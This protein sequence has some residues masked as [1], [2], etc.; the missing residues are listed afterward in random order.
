MEQQEPIHINSI[1]EL[2][3]SPCYPSKNLS[4]SVHTALDFAI[5]LSYSISNDSVNPKETKKELAERHGALTSRHILAMI[6]S[7]LPNFILDFVDITFCNRMGLKQFYP[8]LN[9]D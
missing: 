4:G 3:I 2:M 6:R 5:K 1:T 7:F 8:R 9:I